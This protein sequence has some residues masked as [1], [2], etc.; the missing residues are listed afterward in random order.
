MILAKFLQDE[1]EFDFLLGTEPLLVVKCTATWCSPCKL[2]TPLIDQLASEYVDR[3][4]VFRLD[5]D[6]NK[7]FAKHFKIKSIPS[8]LFFKQGELVETLIGVKP[9]EELSNAVKQLL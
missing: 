8:V 2:M 3:A 9:Y 7:S 6:S 5:I 4:K 1:T